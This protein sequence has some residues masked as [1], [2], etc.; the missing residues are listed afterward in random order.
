MSAQLAQA[1]QAN[2]AACERIV[3]QYG[4][5][6]CGVNFAAL[7][8]SN[9]KAL[10]AFEAAPQQA[11]APFTH[12]VATTTNG[13]PGITIYDLGPS[14]N[15]DSAITAKLIEMG[16]TPPSKQAQAPTPGVCDLVQ[17]DG[18]GKSSRSQ[19]DADSAEL[20]SLCAERDE[21]RRWKSTYAPRLAALEGSLQ[22]AQ[23][24]AA[25]GMEARSALASER[26]ANAI[27]TDELEAQQ[28]QAPI[29][30]DGAESR[31]GFR[32]FDEA[33]MARW[34]TPWQ[35]WREAVKWAAPQQGSK[36]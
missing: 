28:A 16:W 27:L 2:I 10:A 11:Q 20:R 4:A 18:L 30:P 13:R 32:A 26:E 1:L 15:P 5:V 25:Q 7:L 31:A 23:R 9:Q 8:E 29:D 14:L 36:T 24:E 12:A 34:A 6:Q 21:L 33:Q 19:H 35:V 3:E 17:V 22:H